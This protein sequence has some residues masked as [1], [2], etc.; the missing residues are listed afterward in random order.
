VP[1]RTAPLPGFS[2]RLAAHRSRRG[3]RCP[4]ARVA[5]AARSAARFLPLLQ[6]LGWER[7]YIQL[8]R[9][10]T[11]Q[12]LTLTP[13][14][15]RPAALGPRRRPYAGRQS[16]RARACA[17]VCVCGRAW[18]CARVRICASA[19]AGGRAGVCFVRAGVGVGVRTCFCACVC[20]CV[21]VRVCVCVC[22]CACACVCVPVCVRVCL[23]VC[24]CVFVNVCLCARACLCVRVC[25]RRLHVAL[26]VC[27][28][29]CACACACV[30][31][32]STAW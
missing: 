17:C 19:C 11:V 23:C 12:Q 9:D 30:C 29:V 6:E 8:H 10:T 28:C 2:V 15:V 24:E 1:L 18:V 21:C 27:V 7:E 22:V 26:C 4:T 16:T 32:R 25:D 5:A 20:V 14:L 3:T 31:V 13:T